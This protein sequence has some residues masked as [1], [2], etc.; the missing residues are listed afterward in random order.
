MRLIVRLVFV[1]FMMRTIILGRLVLG[2]GGG[3][4]GSLSIRLVIGRV[5]CLFLLD[6]YS[7]IFFAVRTFVILSILLF[8]Q[9]YMG[10]EPRVGKF[11]RF[12][13]LFLGF[14]MLLVFSRNLL[15]LIIG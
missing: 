11:I 12:L 14:I 13:V 1:S 8:S 6:F 3:Y 5:E 10:E 9:W 2:G 7:M 4:L 15:F